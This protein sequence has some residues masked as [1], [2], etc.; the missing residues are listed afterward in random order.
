MAGVSHLRT[1]STRIRLATEM[2]GR[3]D[4]R[5]D[6]QISSN[7]IIEQPPAHRDA[8]G[9]GGYAESGWRAGKLKPRLLP[10]TGEAAPAADNR[11][12]AVVNAAC[13]GNG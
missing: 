10:G 11:V 12:A 9:N 6:H 5:T 2:S 3:D 4:R 13:H 7:A 1:P 8:D